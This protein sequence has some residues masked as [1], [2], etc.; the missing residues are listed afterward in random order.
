MV[1]A[2]LARLQRRYQ[3]RRGLCSPLMCPRSLKENPQ[4]VLFEF[5]SVQPALGVLVWG[6]DP[7][8]G[9]L[10]LCQVLR[11]PGVRAFSSAGEKKEAELLMMPVGE[12][13]RGWCGLVLEAIAIQW[14]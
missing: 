14:P 6:S 11:H 10:G 4:K 8:N 13:L 1:S 3:S 12:K 2:D 9:L 5:A 7:W